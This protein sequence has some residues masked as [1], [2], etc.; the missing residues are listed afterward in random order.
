MS[1]SGNRH[2]PKAA[3]RRLDPVQDYAD[4]HRPIV[5]ALNCGNIG[6]LADVSDTGAATPLTGV[7][8]APAAP[9]ELARKP[10]LPLPAAG[11]SGRRTPIRQARTGKLPRQP[12]REPA[13][14]IRS[15]R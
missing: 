6:Q 13:A 12:Y 1:V 4:L 15:D 9:G 3:A 7:P 5:Q 2:D 14:R 11:L 8:T 10:N